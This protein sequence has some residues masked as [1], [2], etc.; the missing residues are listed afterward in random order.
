MTPTQFPD[1][2]IQAA[3]TRFELDNV[4]MIVIHRAVWDAAVAWERSKNWQEI[5]EAALAELDN[6][7]EKNDAKDTEIAELKATLEAR[8][9]DLELGR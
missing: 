8:S 5:A 3:T 1:A 9:T 7:R 6:E 4:P 2:E